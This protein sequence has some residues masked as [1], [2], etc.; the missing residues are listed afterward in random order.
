MNGE[1]GKGERRRG[2][3]KRSRRDVWGWMLLIFFEIYVYF[4]VG[5]KSTKLGLYKDG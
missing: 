4:F 2:E 5:I 1:R 3:G